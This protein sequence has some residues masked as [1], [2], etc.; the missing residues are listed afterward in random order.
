MAPA[1]KGGKLV[2]LL[3]ILLVTAMAR[4]VTNSPGIQVPATF[5]GKGRVIRWGP[6]AFCGRGVGIFWYS[7]GGSEINS[8]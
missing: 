7:T 5:L 2:E 8:P 6:G 3:P 4:S 1:E